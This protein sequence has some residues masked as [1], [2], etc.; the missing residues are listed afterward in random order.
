ML[1]VSLAGAPMKDWIRQSSKQLRPNNANSGNAISGAKVWVERGRINISVLA[2]AEIEPEIE[3]GNN[4][5]D[6][7]AA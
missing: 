3:E 5:W 2:D 7:E 1:V 6:E 4:P